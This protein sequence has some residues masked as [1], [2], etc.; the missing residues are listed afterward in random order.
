MTL[1]FTI[2]DAEPARSITPVLRF[3]CDVAGPDQRRVHT[4]VVQC[5]VRIEPDQRRYEDDEEARLLDLFGDPERWAD[6]LQAFHWVTV[7]FTV[8]RFTDTT[9]VTIEVPCSYDLEVAAGKYLHA[10]RDGAIPLLFL[11]SGTVFLRDGDGISFQQVP[12]DREAR[13]GLPVAT[14]RGLVDRHWPDSGWLRLS[15]DTLDGLQAHK[16]RHALPT[17]DATLEH[18]LAEAAMP[19][20]AGAGP[21]AAGEVEP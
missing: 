13:F 7:T 5:Q 6:T 2:T 10:L 16:S 20:G 8:P 4:A 14:W 15:R 21:G 9:E 18:L 3:A 11:F 17:W 19:T 12:W 1:D